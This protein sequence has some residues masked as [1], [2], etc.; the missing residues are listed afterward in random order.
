MSDDDI[1]TEAPENSNTHHPIWHLAEKIIIPLALAALAYFGK[2]ASDQIA[3]S[4]VEVA[5]RQVEVAKLALERQA[6][7]SNLTLQLK[8]IELFYDD[9]QNPDPQKRKASISLLA[10]MQ[11]SVAE[12]VARAVAADPTATPEVKRQVSETLTAAQ[13]FGPLGTYRIVIYYER[14]TAAH[15]EQIKTHLLR[16]G[17]NGQIELSERAP[18]FLPDATT[19][20]YHVRY[21]DGFENEAA[22]Y[23]LNLAHEALPGSQ[24]KLVKILPSKGRSD[25]VLT[26]F[27]FNRR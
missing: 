2:K 8:Y 25:A 11:P 12:M 21:D 1:A 13:R 10:A 3:A 16:A 6:T 27:L 15:A 24:F 17:F 18:T 20:G 9:I 22:E 7:E 5:G 19:Y 23:L 26:V 4:Q 14:L